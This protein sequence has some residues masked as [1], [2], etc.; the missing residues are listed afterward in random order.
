MTRHIS[1]EDAGPIT[2][3]MTA[4][5]EQKLSAWEGERLFVY[6]DADGSKPYVP[7]APVKGTL[8]GGR[9]HTGPD[10]K[11]YIGKKIPQEVSDRWFREDVAEAAAIVDRVVT[12]D[13][14]PYQRDTC[15]SFVYNVG[16]GRKGVKDG[17]VELK[18]GGPSTLLRK[19]N[20]GEFD[21]VPGELL[22]W[23]N[24]KGQRNRGLVNRRTAEAGLWAKGAFVASNTV[25]PDAPKPKPAAADGGVLASAGAVVSTVG[26]GTV[27]AAAQQGGELKTALEPLFGQWA[28]PI[29]AGFVIVS[30]GSAI[31]LAVRVAQRRKAE[32]A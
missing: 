1:P 9:G 27:I 14:S 24:S 25:E 13:L 2:G 15:I 16:P 11:P 5:G 4:Y 22:K 18:R 23:V 29:A 10:L 21:A 28:V 7:G 3:V 30:V 32:A 6:D 26:A 12:A 19:I 20:A 17:F 8:T 31:W